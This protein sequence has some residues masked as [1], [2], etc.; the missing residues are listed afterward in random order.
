MAYKISVAPIAHAQVDNIL[1]YVGVRLANP[2]AANS[3]LGDYLTAID[4]LELNAPSFAFLA[5]AEMAKRG[6]RKYTFHNHRYLIIY[7]IEA[8]V[9]EIVGVFH[10]AQN[11]INEL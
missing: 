6:Y 10:T 11:Y 1:L 8:D 7:K 5:D 2:L 9:V 4:T 3:I